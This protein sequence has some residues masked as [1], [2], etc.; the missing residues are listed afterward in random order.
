MT[1]L[2]DLNPRATISEPNSIGRRTVVT[3][4]GET[5]LSYP[6]KN[7][8]R[9]NTS[10]NDDVTGDAPVA[11]TDDGAAII[12]MPVFQGNS[13]YASEA[14]TNYHANP[15][16]EANSTGWTAAGTST[17]S[18]Q[19]GISFLGDYCL[20]WTYGGSGSQTISYTFD[21][22][23]LS[24]SNPYVLVY[25]VRRADNGTVSLVSITTSVEHEEF[26]NTQV[27]LD[28][29]GWTLVYHSFQAP[30][31]VPAGDTVINITFNVNSTDWYIDAVALLDDTG[32][33]EAQYF[34]GSMVGCTWQGTEHESPSDKADTI[35]EYDHVVWD[36]SSPGAVIMW[37][38]NLG[39]ARPLFYFDADN[40]TLSSG[41]SKIAGT[42]VT[43]ASGGYL[44]LISLSWD[45]VGTWTRR[46]QDKNGVTITKS[47]GS[48]TPD[49]PISGSM[50]VGHSNGALT[51]TGRFVMD[52]L[53]FLYEELTDTM[54]TNI[55]NSGIGYSTR[56]AP[57]V[58]LSTRPILPIAPKHS[59]QDLTAVNSVFLISGNTLGIR[60]DI[61]RRVITMN[62]PAV[63]AI[64]PTFVAYTA[65]NSTGATS[66]TVARPTG[67]TDDD[68]MFAYFWVDSTSITITPPSGW[69]LLNSEAVSGHKLSGYWKRYDTSD[70]DGPNYTFGISSSDGCALIVASFRGCSA[71]ATP[72]S[73]TA[74]G[75]GTSATVYAVDAEN[76]SVLMYAVGLQ[77]SSVDVSPPTDYTFVA[78]TEL[79][80]SP[81]G[82]LALSYKIDGRAEGNISSALDGSTEW[83][84]M[85]TKMNPA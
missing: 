10:L 23:I 6:I 83:L 14:L 61:L 41:T 43:L 46:V 2:S 26:E 72:L 64:P 12:Y 49:P 53:A 47:T 62:V 71:V 7:L 55:F 21:G 27:D 13:L 56:N 81:F 80:G 32:V 34:D 59:R 15:S 50:Y 85:Y 17:V 73:N 63:A 42:S 60:S 36:T 65:T 30:A 77:S 28:G 19:A 58:K 39:N 48:Y 37:V 31:I 70:G 84:A 78:E 45:G 16:I 76:N 29:S 8:F 33:F 74:S 52:D 9:F 67:T 66:L 51:D 75:S 25:R 44:A 5:V 1:N 3:P 22:T 82:S 79:S 54:F 24:S 35:L 68:M 20:K 57:R 11:G 4:Q 40:Y 38:M 18:R 69:T